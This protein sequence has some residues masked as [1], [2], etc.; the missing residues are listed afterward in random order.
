MRRQ[1]RIRRGEDRF[2]CRDVARN[3]S[4]YSVST[5]SAGDVANY[6]STELQL[7]PPTVHNVS[8]YSVTGRGYLGREKKGDSFCR[9]GHP[10]SCKR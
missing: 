3:V 7:A 6:V 10:T 8:G 1:A 2:S 9:A 4:A 5:A